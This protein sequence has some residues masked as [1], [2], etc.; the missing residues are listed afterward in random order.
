MLEFLLYSV[1]FLSAVLL[2]LV[3]LVQ[4]SKGGG[5]G[6]A[7]GGAG[8]ETFGPRAGGINRFT[9]GLF[10]VW[11]LS[12]LALH[13]TSGGAEEGSVMGSEPETPVVEQ[14][15]PAPLPPPG[16]DT[17]PTTPEQGG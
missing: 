6:E 4:E 5:L 14:Q 9:F 12:A 11:I 3:I 10:G 8:Q 16:G 1:F 17:A 2:I 15:E 7:F 13:W